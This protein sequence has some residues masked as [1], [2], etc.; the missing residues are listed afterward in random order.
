[1]VVP[2]SGEVI[3]VPFEYCYTRSLLS[4]ATHP[5]LFASLTTDLATANSWSAR[6]RLRNGH[7]VSGHVFLLTMSVLFLVD[8]IT[9]SFK[10]AL[11]TPARSLAVAMNILLIAIWML[12]TSTTA[13]YFHTPFEKF[14]GFRA[15]VFS[16]VRDGDIDVSF[17]AQS[18]VLPPSALPNSLC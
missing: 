12:A 6:P 11:W 14:T 7:D 17:F 10:S 1:M 18:L 4:P 5:T 8:Q 9:H 15:L 3:D 2:E 16:Y 13:L